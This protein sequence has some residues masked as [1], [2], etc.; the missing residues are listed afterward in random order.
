MEPW[1]TPA[2]TFFH[3]ENC[4]LR[5]TRCFVSF[6]KSR[7]RFSKFPDMP[8]RYSLKMIP[9]CHTLSNTFAISRNILLT[10]RPSSKELYISWVIDNNWLIQE[11]PGLKPDWLKEI[12]LFPRKN[13]KI[14]LSTN[15]SRIFPHI[16]SSDTRW[17]FFN[18][19]LSPFQYLLVNI[20]LS[21]I[22]NS[23]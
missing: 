10:S 6:K 5:I 3:V 16:G 19:C 14:S 13:F 2:L 23:V 7:K 18:I 12:S 15:L 22:K 20:S 21:P 8:F 9:S 1:G 17:Y 11:S 4:P